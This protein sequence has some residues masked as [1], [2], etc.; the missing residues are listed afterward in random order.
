MKEKQYI[1]DNAQLMAEWDWDKNDKLGLYPQELTHGTHKKA[2]WICNKNHSWEAA[3]SKRALGSS[4]PICQGKKI[5]IG[6]NDLSTTNSELLKEWDFEKNIGIHPTDFSKGSN[7]KVWWICN[8]G[9][10]W[11]AVIA[12]RAEGRQC[13]ICKGKTILPGYNDLSTTHPKLSTEWDVDKNKNISPTNVGKGSEQKVWW[14]CERGHSWQAAV[15]SRVS[16]VGC[17]ICAKEL[18]S[19]YPEKALFFYISKIFPTA[20]SGYKSTE[21]DSFELDIFI[22]THRIAIEYDG[23]RWHQDIN[24]DIAKNELCQKLNIDLIRVRE[25]KCPS[26]PSGHSTIITIPN[27]KSG[28]DKIIYQVLDELKSKT[29]IDYSFCVDLTK[30]NSAILGLLSTSKK[31]N[32]VAL[33][34]PD[35]INKWDTIKNGNVSPYDVSAGS[36]KKAWWKCEKGHSYNASISSKVRG[37]GCPI[38][39]GKKA[40]KGFNDFAT[41]CSQLLVE[42]D[43]E[44]NLISPYEITFG[45]D[46][47]TWWKCENGHS[48]SATINNKRAGTSCP[49]CARN[50]RKTKSISVK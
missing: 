19:S 8:E 26:I 15:Y 45:S 35:L 25:P 3:I 48:Y 23:E 14:L 5:L 10:S 30:D 50:K 49:I 33:T 12:K 47:K 9:H 4:C 6:Y 21:L 27:K 46:K 7:K 20:I 37:R 34:H 32:S 44:K 22:P 18:Q 42:W 28:L 29:N 11:E 41:H 2:W 24:R 39:A 13:P 17:P 16:G 43:Y 38:C 40:E 31:E 36:D 1:I